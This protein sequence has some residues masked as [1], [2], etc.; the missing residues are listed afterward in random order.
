MQKNP[1]PETF[2]VLEKGDTL[3][4]SSL[5]HSKKNW[6]LDGKTIEG[7]KVVA[8][9]DK[10]GLVEYGLVRVIKGK[11][12]IYCVMEDQTKLTTS[13]SSSAQNYQTK[14]SGA[15]KT[16][17]YVKYP[18]GKFEGVSYN[19][20][21]KMV[22]DCEPAMKV[23]ESQFAGTYTK[24]HPDWLTNDYNRLFKVIETYNSKC[25]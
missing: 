23:L 13:Y 6:T 9:Q 19:E 3:K 1:K 7:S 5:K 20:L 14:M 16:E 12:N 4:G 11:L 10:Y 25:P 17:F 24:K 15:T 22:Q 18:N 8:Y 21:K 2:I